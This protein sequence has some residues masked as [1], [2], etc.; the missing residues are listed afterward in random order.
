MEA[1]PLGRSGYRLRSREDE[2]SRA[3]ENKGR[4]MAK[5]EGRW[6]LKKK[7]FI[8]SNTLWNVPMVIRRGDCVNIREPC[9]KGHSISVPPTGVVLMGAAQT[10]LIMLSASLLSARGREDGSL[11]KDAICGN[12]TDAPLCS[13]T[14]LTAGFLCAGSCTTSEG[15]KHDDTQSKIIWHKCRALWRIMLSTK[16]WFC[17][18]SSPHNDMN[19]Q[20][21]QATSS[22]FFAWFSIS[23][24][25]QA[26]ERKHIRGTLHLSIVTSE[27]WSHFPLDLKSLDA[28]LQI[29]GDQH[30]V[31]HCRGAPYPPP[32][33]PEDLW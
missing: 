5:A 29:C 21:R 10:H 20:E 3:G 19:I 4:K 27:I 28:S 17:N 11:G 16:F 15:N 23:V 13:D 32:S 18:H 1:G 2:G 22:F 31:I 24:C 12:C 25:T 9:G 26:H 7:S 6:K 30:I 33:L 14:I 8:K